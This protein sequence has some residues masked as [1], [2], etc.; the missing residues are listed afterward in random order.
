M[1]HIS[2]DFLPCLWQVAAALPT[3]AR[4]ILSNDEEVLTDAAWALSFLSDG[5]NEQIQSV[6]DAG[7][8]SRL[9]ELLG[10]ASASV[11][12][13][14]LRT[15]GNIVTGEEKQTQAVIDSGGL[16]RLGALLL[17]PKKGIRKEACWTISNITAGT[18]E[19]IQSVVDSNV[20]PPIVELLKNATELDVKKEAAWVISGVISGSHEHI[21][22]VVEKQCIP[23]L[24][25]LLGVQD[26]KVVTVALAGL[27]G[28]LKAAQHEAQQKGQDSHSY[29]QMIEAHGGLSK[30]KRL[31][32]RSDKVGLE[33]RE[34]L[35]NFGV[36]MKT[37]P[38]QLW[39]QFPSGLLTKEEF[40]QSF[41]R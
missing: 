2:P 6:L 24:C 23:P 22:F 19:Q 25:N 37:M 4:L 8:C 9:V 32:N 1:Y 27:D 3:L 29:G 15:V 39:N 7:V 40:I 14:A 12:T 34:M 5:P 36:I 26:E 35:Q 31:Q 38:E 13:P 20:I 17:S 11:V 41:S 30:L 16:A 33:A 18:R 21:K 10:H 28:I